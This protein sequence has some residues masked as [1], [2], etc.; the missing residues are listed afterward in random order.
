MELLVVTLAQVNPAREADASARIR[1]ISDAV[2]NAPGLLNARFYRS[3]QPGI[4]YCM[5]TT[6]ESAEWWQKAQE[7]HSPYVLVQDSPGG[8]FHTPPDQWLMQFLWGYSRPRAQPAV[9]AAHLVLVRP[10]MAERVQQSWLES[11][12][13]QAVE[14]VLAFALLARSIDEEAASAISA[15]SSAAPTAARASIR[16]G[17]IFF[18]LLSWPDERYRE[19]FYADE[20]YKQMRSLLNRTGMMHILTLDPL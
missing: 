15:S 18:N 9:A 8:I 6:W 7:R 2:R 5:L 10:E 3:R 1:I 4:A 16:Q 13:R 17:A 11:L 19:D 14:P 12:R 20:Q